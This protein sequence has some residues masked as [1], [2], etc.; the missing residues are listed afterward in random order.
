MEFEFEPVP[1]LE[2]EL[3][4]KFEFELEFEFEF[5]IENG[6]E[7]HGLDLH[8]AR[9]GSRYIFRLRCHYGGK[10]SN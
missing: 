6:I 5:E 4:L 10:Y 1:E 7:I 2:L 9:R 3:E 8:C